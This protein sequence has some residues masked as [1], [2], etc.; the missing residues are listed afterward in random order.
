MGF[1]QPPENRGPFEHKFGYNPD[2]DGSNAPEDITP[3]G[4]MYWP[5]SVVAAADIDIVSSSVEDKGT[6]TAGSGAQAIRIFG[7]DANYKMIEETVIL[8]GQTDVHPTKDYLRIYRARIVKNAGAGAENAGNITIDINGANTLAMLLAGFSQTTQLAY[9]I[10]DD[11]V[12]S[13]LLSFTVGMISQAAGKTAEGR[14]FHRDFG[15]VW[16][17]EHV[18]GINSNDRYPYTYPMNFE[19]DVKS[20]IRIQIFDASADNLKISGV[21]GIFLEG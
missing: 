15:G 16:H 2:L 17:V 11:F 10:P 13:W 7:L 14:L 3:F 1:A 19:M 21:M 18:F 4:N 8:N 9:T 20:D 6:P 5:D 12:T